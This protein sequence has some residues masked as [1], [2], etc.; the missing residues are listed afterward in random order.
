MKLSKLLET[1]EKDY[2]LQ[3]LLKNGGY[4][5][6]SDYKREYP[7]AWPDI[8]S[9]TFSISSNELRTLD[10]CPQKILGSFFCSSNDLTDLKGGPKIVSRAYF[11]GN[12]ALMNLSDAPLDVDAFNFNMNKIK[13]LEGIGRRY[14]K[15]C[16]SINTLNN[17]ISTNMLGLVL[18]RSLHFLTYSKEVE[19]MSIIEEY[20]NQPENVLDCKERLINLGLKEQA[21]L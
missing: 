9:G 6:L 13:S 12:N 10:G 20:V 8:I 15:K 1:E 21:K 4:A 19:G 17:P 2:E 14:L 7:D 5:T 11:C 3:G 16:E 18:V